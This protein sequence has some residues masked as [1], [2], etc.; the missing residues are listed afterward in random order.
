MK[1][2]IIILLLVF[3]LSVF[4]QEKQSEKCIKVTVERLDHAR[5]KV[6]ENNKC[7]NVITVKSYLILEWKKIQAEK[8]KNRKIKKI[9]K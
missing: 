7:T 3:N 4:S 1:N 9:K 6:T 2:L 8:R 5:V